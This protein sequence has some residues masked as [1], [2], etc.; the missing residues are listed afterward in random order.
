MTSIEPV[1]WDHGYWR[2]ETEFCLNLRIDFKPFKVE[3]KR[4]KKAGTSYTVGPVM[5]WKRAR[6]VVMIGKRPS[7]GLTP[8]AKLWAETATATLKTQWP[9]RQPIP[10][11]V[12]VTAQ[13][14]SYLPDSRPI[15]ASN[16]YQGPE[17][18]LQACRKGCKPDCKLHA[19]IL[20]DDSQVENH[21]GSARLIDRD[22]PRVEITLRPFV[23]SVC[24]WCGC[25]HGG[26]PE[27][28]PESQGRL[29]TVPPEMDVETMDS[30]VL[31]WSLFYNEIP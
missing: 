20:S 12:L 9:F 31:G 2:D 24:S 21:D 26:G 18:V 1:V 28:C 14:V 19:G 22:F 17:D 30:R 13:V 29:A 4:G 5:S 23:R 10:K 16:L 11:H 15:D 6:Q 3:I 27:L 7:I 25:S 8:R